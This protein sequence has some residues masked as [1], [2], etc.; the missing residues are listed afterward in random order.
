METK[1]RYTNEFRA[2]CLKK[3]KQSGKSTDEF[4]KEIGV[5][6][7]LLRTWRKRAEQAP[8]STMREVKERG[9]GVEHL[10]KELM[11]FILNFE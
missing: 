9:R 4:S 10:K 6:G 5:A 1:K 3:L 8:L 7:S 11:K 2:E